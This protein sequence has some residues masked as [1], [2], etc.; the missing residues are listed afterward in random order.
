M[1]RKRALALAAVAA[2]AGWQ[3]SGALLQSAGMHLCDMQAGG[4]RASLAAALLRRSFAS[5]DDCARLESGVGERTAAERHLGSADGFQTITFDQLCRRFPAL[6]VGEDAPPPAPIPASRS[7]QQR[8]PPP[9]RRA[10]AAAVAPRRPPARSATAA[11]AAEAAE[12]GLFSSASSRSRPSFA[13]MEEEEEEEAAAASPFMT[14]RQKAV[15]D[16]REKGGGGRG[17]SRSARSSSMRRPSRHSGRGGR[18]GSDERRGGL[19][20]R[21]LKRAVQRVDDGDAD[22]GSRRSTGRSLGVKRKFVSPLASSEDR[23][24]PRQKRRRGGGSGGG[25]G[26]SGGRGRGGGGGKRREE[27]GGGGAGEAEDDEDVD[28]R[29][30]MFPPELVERIESE[31]IDQGA[32]VTWDDIAGLSFAKKCVTELIVW[33]MMRPDIFT[34]LRKL[35][36]GILLFGPPGTGKTLIGKAVASQTGATFFSISASSLT[37]KWI[38]EGEKTVRALFAVAAVRSPAVVFIDEIDSLLTQRS[39][40]E[41]EASRRIK[42]EFLVQLDGVGNDSDARVIVMGATN[43][44]QELDDAAR[45]R[46]VKRLY[47]PLPD[48]D[49][50]AQLLSRLMKR[51]AHALSEEDMAEI[52]RRTAGYSGADV[53]NLCCEAAMGPIRDGGNIAVMAAGDVRD[54]ALGDFETA[55]KQVRASVSSSDLQAYLEW[56]DTFGSGL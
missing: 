48:D 28:P 37:S 6:S 15:L 32:P 7:L 34:G 42:T 17:S 41:N 1:D 30:K 33:P 45:R 31:I 24:P 5:L 4:E 13:A 36:K 40:G 14:A 39:D 19:W 43:R 22:S 26:S 44:P 2:P 25:G 9:A 51:V 20:D 21:G 55:L 54:V 50:R 38:G 46:F 52:V 56:N 18:G 23:S 12:R 3:R 27:R 10:A 11:A 47:I 29:L 8:R 35:P 49:A 16:D 53:H